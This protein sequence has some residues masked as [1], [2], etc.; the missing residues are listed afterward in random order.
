MNAALLQSKVYGGYAKAALRIGYTYSIYRPT[1]ATAPLS[2]GYYIGKTPAAFTTHKAGQFN[3]D[4]PNDYNERSLF[5]A[6]L[7]GSLVQVG[8]FL[9]AP[10]SAGPDIPG[11]A[12]GPFY[13]ASKDPITPMLAVICTRV[14][15]I[16]APGP[17]TTTAGYT[18]GSYAGTIIE[19]G[20]ANVVPLIVDW[21]AQISQ[22]ARSVADKLLPGDVGEGMWTILLSA[23]A[24]VVLTS[25]M[26]IE[27]DLGRHYAIRTAELTPLGWRIAAQETHT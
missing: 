13:I 12:I 18:P 24:G 7:D 16:S 20:A 19:T 15:T 25:A 17:S 27:D 26:L 3:F 4:K 14:I 8:D 21:P 2:S 23:P 22:G 9:V 11:A 6:L 10:P 1:T 5:H